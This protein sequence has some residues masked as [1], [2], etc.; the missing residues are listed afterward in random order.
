M[1]KYRLL[2]ERLVE[3]GVLGAD[4]LY[5]PDPIPWED[6]R[7]V[8]DAAYVEAIAAGT[9]DAEMQRRIGFPWSP[10]MVERS[11]RSVGAT[12]AASRDVL[13]APAL[14]TGGR[15]PVAA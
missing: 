9:I 8:H 1:A 2:R 13:A 15:L 7:L 3:A 14:R 12:L 10:M 4:E 6:L 5:I 11:R